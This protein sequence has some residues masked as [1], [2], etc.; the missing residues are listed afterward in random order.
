[1]IALAG[2]PPV[3]FERVVEGKAL[4]VLLRLRVENP[5]AT[6]EWLAREIIRLAGETV[7]RKQVSRTLVAHGM[8]TMKARRGYLSTRSRAQPVSP[9]ALVALLAARTDH[10]RRQ[11]MR[12]E[13]RRARKSARTLK[14]YTDRYRKE[15]RRLVRRG[16]L[17]AF[18]SHEAERAESRPQ[19]T[20]LLPGVCTPGY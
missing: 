1:M 3:R 2:R 10:A 11:E 9:D 19:V 7:D 15:W 4:E 5:G 20:A 8:P 18:A 12:A 16:L 14:S 17:G 6:S 13:R